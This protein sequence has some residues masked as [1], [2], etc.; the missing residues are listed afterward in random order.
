MRHILPPFVPS[1]N[2]LPNATVVELPSSAGIY[3]VRNVGT[4]KFWLC[5]NVPASTDD[6]LN[7]TVLNPHDTEADKGECLTISRSV[8]SRARL[9]AVSLVGSTLTVTEV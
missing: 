3:V 4:G 6:V 8:T 2:T 9:F 1:S 7:G 5:N